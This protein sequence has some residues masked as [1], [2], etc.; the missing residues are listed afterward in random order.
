[1]TLKADLRDEIIVEDPVRSERHAQE[2]T[3]DEKK[4]HSINVGPLS[5]PGD[6]K[7]DLSW[8]ITGLQAI[9]QHS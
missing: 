8:D 5:R 6:K 7:L 1:M 9:N 2:S 4:E 3:R